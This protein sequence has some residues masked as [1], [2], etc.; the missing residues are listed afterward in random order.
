MVVENLA[1]DQLGAPMAALSSAGTLVYVIPGSAMR[2]LVWVSR[3]GIESPINDTPRPYQNPR[4][5]PDGTR[6]VVEVFGG[7]LWLQDVTRTTFPRLTSPET[8]GNTFAVWT[9]D[10]NGWCF[11]R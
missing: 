11:E 9:H 6:I 7:H 4:L 5:G 3:Q 8:I 2:R 1:L 10:S